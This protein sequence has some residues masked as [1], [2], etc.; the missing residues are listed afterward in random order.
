V[1]FLTA[2]ESQHTIHSEDSPEIGP[3]RM[4][5]GLQSFRKPLLAILAIMFAAVAI[6]YSGLWTVYGNQR[7]PVELGFDNQYIPADHS[8]V[9]QSVVPGS[10]AERAGM[11][12]GDRIIRINGVPLEEDTLIRIWSQHK[13]GDSVELAVQ[14][15]GVSDP[16]VLR[17]T[18]GRAATPRRR[19]DWR[20]TWDWASFA[21]IPLLFSRWD[22]R[23]CSFAWRTQTP[24]CWP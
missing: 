9:V 5:R 2:S 12:P 6:V 11:K 1:C 7:L 17:G 8:Q 13:P 15:P 10:P 21:C 14:R 20:R 4:M 16:I 24:G 23:S 18:F 19:R 22:W 3:H